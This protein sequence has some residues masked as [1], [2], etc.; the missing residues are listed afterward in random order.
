MLLRYTGHLYTRKEQKDVPFDPKEV[1]RFNP[2]PMLTAEEL[3][4]DYL[5]IGKQELAL[6]QYRKALSAAPP[7]SF[8]TKIYARRI[9]QLEKQ[10]ERIQK[11]KQ[12]AENTEPAG[13][14]EEVEQK[15][16]NTESAGKAEEAKT[17]NGK[18]EEKTS[19]K[20]GKQDGEADSGE[21]EEEGGE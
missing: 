8:F 21:D 13:K 6:E 3:A 15:T 7:D 2:I 20:A 19:E 1:D 9:D 4:L 17:D 12:Q 10:A 14:V 5:R 18:Q 11:A 16:E